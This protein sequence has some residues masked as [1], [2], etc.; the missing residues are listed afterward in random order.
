MTGPMGGPA[1]DDGGS[2]DN[3]QDADSGGVSIERLADKLYQLLLD[4]V[5]SERQRG[6][7]DCTH[8]RG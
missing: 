6:L 2:A 4:E 8:R 7:A 3:P 5:R 1:P